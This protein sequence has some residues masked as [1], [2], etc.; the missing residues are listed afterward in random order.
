MAVTIGPIL[1]SHPLYQDLTM[2]F[3]RPRMVALAAAMA[4]SLAA[5]KGAQAQDSTASIHYKGVTLT[6]VGFVAAEGVW[7]QRNITADIGSSFTAIPFSGTSA[8]NMTET[9]LTGRQSRFGMLATGSSGDTKFS[10][11]FE[12]DFLGVGT[13]SNANESNSYVLRVRQF[14]GSVAAGNGWTFGAG[15]SWS[16]LTTNKTGMAYRSEAIPLTID[17]QYSVGFNWARQAGFRLTNKMSDVATFGI[18]IEE[19][20]STFSGRNLPT[21]FIIGQA[22]GSTLN[23]TN[24]YSTD[25]SPDLI[26][27]LAFD[28]KD[29]GHWE[30]KGLASSFRDRVFDPTNVSGGTRNATNYGFGL[31]FGVYIPLMADG[32]DVM[33]FGLSGLWGQGIGRYGSSQLPDATV[34][35]TGTLTPITAGMALL[36]LET[37][38][39][40]NF[41]LY[42]YIG[43]EFAGR[44][45]FVNAA[46]KGVGYGSALNSNAGCQTEAAPTSDFAP[47]AGTCNAD[48]RALWQANLGFWYR[49]YKGAAGTVQWGMHYSY[50]SRNTWSDAAGNQPQAIDNMLFTSFRYVLP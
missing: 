11:F 32:R 22:G 21:D 45:D 1:W 31:G 49:F 7:R 23:A 14:W 4:L 9:H 30:L 29:M 41:D 10:G 3:V 42:G 34:T 39:T 44:S 27:K 8:G 24:N 46:G 15:Q 20:Q 16:L 43:A 37:H 19:S 26:V 36:S 28:P 13:S 5:L 2:T 18:A 48:T 40:K 38:P 35:N 6:P 33:D 12:S 50:T 25:Y 17:A 47:A